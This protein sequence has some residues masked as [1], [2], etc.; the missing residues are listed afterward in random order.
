[1]RIRKTLC[2]FLLL[3]SVAQSGATVAQNSPAPTRVPPSRSKPSVYVSFLRFGK[4][5]PVYTGESNERVWLSLHNNTRWTL[6]LD[7]RGA[8]GQSFSRGD[9]KEIGLFVS[10]EEVP[11]SNEFRVSSVSEYRSAPLAPGLQENTGLSQ[12]PTSVVVEEEKNCSA[13]YIDS[14]HVCSN[15]KLAPGKSL[16]FSVPRETLCKNLKIYIVYNYDW[17]GREG[18]MGEEP[19]HRVYFYGSSLPKPSR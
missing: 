14:C 6:V 17:E 16:V 15:I 5:E 11:K 12:P 7:A 19:E 4:R 13:P 2:G 8:G 1:M 10:V 18:F 3:L 9:E